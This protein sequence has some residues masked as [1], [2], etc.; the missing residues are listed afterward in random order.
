[1]GKIGKL[2]ENTAFIT[3][4][5]KEF[6]KTIIEQRFEKILFSSYQKLR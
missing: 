2:I 1:M 6:Y 5:R 3:E 4:R